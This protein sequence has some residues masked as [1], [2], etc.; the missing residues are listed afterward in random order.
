MTRILDVLYAGVCGSDRSRL[1]AGGVVGELGHEAVCIHNG[2]PVVVRPFRG[3]GLCAQCADGRE[4]SCATRL[5]LGKTPGRAGAFSGQ[6]EVHDEQ[7]YQVPLDDPGFLPAFVLTDGVACI[8]NGLGRLEREP[9]SWSVVGRGSI[10][11]SA[12]LVLRRWFPRARRIETG[13]PEED[14]A[15]LVVEAGGPRINAS[16]EAALLRSADRGT[17]LSC[18]VFPES[19]RMPSPPRAW[20]EREV[21]LVGVNSY[22]TAPSGEDDFD[23]AVGLVGRDIESFAGLVQTVDGPGAVLRAIEG[24]RTA[25]KST[26]AFTRQGD[27]S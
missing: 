6:I 11:Q 4:A 26:I 25:P 14:R 19:E 20:L 10:A 24:P 22:R 1:S 23:V 3:C 17:V 9:S 18:S 15:D 21:A 7:L 27:L 8:V 16:L 2:L 12:A 13:A 5:A